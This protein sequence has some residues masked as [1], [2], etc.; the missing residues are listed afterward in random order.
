MRSRPVKPERPDKKSDTI[1][2]RVPWSLKRDFMER[3]RQEGRPA[4]DI[5]RDWMEEYLRR[6]AQRTATQKLETAMTMIRKRP[7]AGFAAVLG[8][9]GISALIAGALPAGAAPDLLP[10]F[11]GMDQN[12]DGLI[13]AAEYAQTGLVV[14]ADALEVFGRESDRWAIYA[15]EPTLDAVADPGLS[16]GWESAAN[17]LAPFDQ[18][19]DGRVSLSE[20]EARFSE[21][22]DRAF[23]RLDV[24]DDGV[25]DPQGSILD[26][27]D[28]NGDGRI[29]RREFSTVLVLDRL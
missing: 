28:D 13:D 4:S 9:A 5:F 24:D 23:R 18:N 26:M 16:S 2:F 14:K 12:G 8:A 20:W 7:R 6:P 15:G 22:A 25:L 29:S 27:L 19:G 11:E 17:P 21:A 1:K 10:A 3:A